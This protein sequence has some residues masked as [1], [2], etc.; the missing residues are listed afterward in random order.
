SLGV[1]R[2][3]LYIGSWPKGK[4]AVLRDGKWVDLGRLGDATEVI[5]LA[6]YNG[7]FYAGTIPRAEVFRF[8][9][10]EK[11][12]SIRRL[13]NPPRFEPVPV[14]SGAKEVQDWS[15]AS[16]L[17]VYQGKM[18]VSTATCY[19]TNI[20]SAL[21]KEIRGKVYSFATGSVVSYDEDLGAG[22]KH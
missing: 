2:G 21:P 15:R 14:G 3:E 22:W 12:T 16:S 4:V 10:P 8:D 17:A 19:R 6:N 11:W 18:F 5:G 9:G 7:S 13:F 20:E 1:Y